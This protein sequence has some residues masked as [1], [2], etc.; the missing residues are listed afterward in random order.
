MSGSEPIIDVL[1]VDDEKEACANLKNIIADYF[2]DGINIVG[3]AYS[4][5]EAE[6]QI[7]KLQ[8]DAVFLD[9]EM[10]NENAFR[11]LERISPVTFEV[12]FVTAYDEYAIRAFKL[13]AV[14]YI[15]KPI[16]ILELGQAINRLKEKIKVKKILTT[17]PTTYADLAHQVA[18]KIKGN[19]ITLKDSNVI[20]VVDFK[21]IFFVEAQGSYIRVVFQKDNTVKEIIMS[22]SLTDYEE[23]LPSDM[24]FRIHKT[25]VINCVHVNKIIK[26]EF[27]EAVIGGKYN[28]PVSRRRYTALLDF[29]KSNDYYNE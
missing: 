11:F 15:L 7:S 10:P 29:L 12:V 22:G 28:L 24:F 1:I 14:D 9:I 25:Y 26:G 16:S 20:E 27:A 8:P 3:K 2:D 4:T 6:K 5:R 19:K 23:L 13:N 17:T 21:E 18:N